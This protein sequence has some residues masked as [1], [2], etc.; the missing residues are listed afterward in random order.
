MHVIGK[1]IRYNY[2]ASHTIP[3]MFELVLMGPL[4]TPSRY[5]LVGTTYLQVVR[6]YYTASRVKTVC[7]LGNQKSVLAKQATTLLNFFTTAAT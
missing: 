6:I 3:F 5:V 2:F 4:T 7:A 1:N